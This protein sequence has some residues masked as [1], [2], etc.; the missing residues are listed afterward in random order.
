ML[1]CAGL[2]S[3]PLVFAQSAETASTEK[4]SAQTDAAKT[5]GSHEVEYND[6]NYRRFMELKDQP[7]QS[8]SLPT[9]AFNPGKQKLDELPEASQKHLRNQLRQIIMEA[10]EWAPG[11]ENNKYPYVA[12]EAAQEDPGLKQQEAEAW[13]ELV[14]KYQ[15]REAQIYANS[16]RPKFATGGKTGAQAASQAQAQTQAQADGAESA[17]ASDSGA[18]ANS[19]QKG[20]GQEQEQQPGEEK[21]SASSASKDA[22]SSSS[23]SATA[24]PDDPDSASQSGVSQ[25]AL[26]YL[27][28]NRD[29]GNSKT[30]G[31]SQSTQNQSAQNQ[32]AQ[33]QS[34]QS[35]STQNQS[36]QNQSTQPQSAES[37]STAVQQPGQPVV[38]SSDTLSV[39]DLQ[40]AQGISI[41][42]G[43]GA[44]PATVIM[45][46]K[47]NSDNPRKDED[48]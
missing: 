17:A 12:S 7:A 34:A 26:Q 8:S 3:V 28:S 24:N 18:D 41:S 29:A 36:A 25:S 14:G 5:S 44:T 39:K 23:S 35:Q 20:D 33:N 30:A 47:D 27:M 15:E 2:V 31:D 46:A 48:G 21:Q 45:R 22:R 9:N 40:N 32:S 6:D 43:A 13:G 4:G 38:F 10:G 11:D 42:T 1:L 19:G 37:Q 16:S